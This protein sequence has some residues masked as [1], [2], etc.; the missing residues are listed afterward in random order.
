MVCHWFIYITFRKIMLATPNTIL[1]M[2]QPDQNEV[3]CHIIYNTKC[4][5]KTKIFYWNNSHYHLHL[6]NHLSIFF[7]FIHKTQNIQRNIKK[8]NFT[9]THGLCNFH[10]F[11]IFVKK[12]KLFSSF[13]IPLEQ[14]YNNKNIKFYVYLRDSRHGVLLLQKKKTENWMVL[15]FFFSVVVVVVVRWWN[16]FLFHCQK[17]MSSYHTFF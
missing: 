12:K 3:I 13:V 14:F 6:M 1:K 10:S 17:D 16:T 4:D 11:N 7:F 5:M 8:W 9:L 15:V 2:P